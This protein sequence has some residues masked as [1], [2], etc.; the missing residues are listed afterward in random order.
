MTLKIGWIKH[1]NYARLRHHCEP[2]GWRVLFTH[3]SLGCCCCTRTL[4][5]WIKS[6]EA[7]V[8]KQQRE[9]TLQSDCRSCPK[10]CATSW[11]S[12]LVF[13]SSLKPLWP[14]LTWQVTQSAGCSAAR[15]LTDVGWAIAALIPHNNVVTA[16]LLEVLCE[17]RGF[18]TFAFHFS[19]F[20]KVF[21]SLAHL[22]VPTH[23]SGD[24]LK[25]LK[26]CSL[27]CFYTGFENEEPIK[28]PFKGS[29]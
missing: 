2:W 14:P 15:R 3:W 28:W 1:Y 20:F 11:D 4:A 13:W 7:G 6:Q 27:K 24:M 5:S 26:S 8:W 9:R 12:N 29:P 10:G 18:D 25:S 16:L 21:W 23:I 22:C 17:L 19:F